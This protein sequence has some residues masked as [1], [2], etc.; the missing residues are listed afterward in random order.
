MSQKKAPTESHL[1]TSAPRQKVANAPFHVPRQSE[2]CRIYRSTRTR[3][4]THT[5]T[6]THPQTLSHLRA[7]ESTGRL[8]T[9]ERSAANESKHGPSPSRTLA[10]GANPFPFDKTRVDVALRKIRRSAGISKNTRDLPA[11]KYRDLHGEKKV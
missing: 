7:N 11:H 2:I 8:L 10:S 6:H 3:T 5:H 1:H 4:H 9:L